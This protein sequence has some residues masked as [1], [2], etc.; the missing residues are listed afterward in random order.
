MR[1][2]N[3]EMLEKRVT[4]VKKHDRPKNS[5]NVHITSSSEN[6]ILPSIF[7]SRYDSTK[8]I[9]YMY[10]IEIQQTNIIYHNKHCRL[11]QEICRS[12]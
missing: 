12:R 8:Y 9:N 4:K 1:N 5:P 11:F 2:E 7:Q 6:P 10:D 3:K